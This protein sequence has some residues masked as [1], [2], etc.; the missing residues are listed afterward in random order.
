MENCLAGRLGWFKS[1][2]G[3]SGDTLVK[4]R[5]A[6]DSGVSG[7]SGQVVGKHLATAQ[8]QS[9]H[10]QTLLRELR[11]TD[12]QAVRRGGLHNLLQLESALGIQFAVFVCGA[13]SATMH[14]QHVRV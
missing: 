10:L 6:R 11:P 3:C 8:E 2:L 1:G 13:L 12:D 5:V 14:N 7:N 4:R 9:L